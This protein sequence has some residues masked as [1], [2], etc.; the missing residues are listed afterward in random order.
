MTAASKSMNISVEKTVAEQSILTAEQV[1]AA[2]AEV[3]AQAETDLRG[4]SSEKQFEEFKNHWLGRKSGV[5]TKI[6]D[7]WLKQAPTDLKKSVGQEFN[8]FK[9]ALETLIEERRVGIEA[10]AGEAAGAKDRGGLSFPGGGRGL[11]SR[12]LVR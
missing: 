2:F 5:V 6:T 10:G 9:T 11:G 7:N 4:V 12:P 1:G 3:R 8:K